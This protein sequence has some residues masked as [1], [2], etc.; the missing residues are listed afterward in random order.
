MARAASIIR[1]G[2]LVAFPTE[3]VYGL[4]ANALDQAAVLRI[5]AAKERA[6]HDPLIVHIAAVEDLDAVAARLPPLTGQLAARFWPGPLTLVVPRGPAVAPAVSAGLD[7]VAV[8][9]PSHAVALAVIRAAGVPIAAPSA[10]RF[11][12]TSATTAAHV[13]DDLDGRIDLILD[14]GPATVGVESTVLD[15]CSSPPRLLRPGAIPV[16]AIVAVIGEVAFG[17]PPAV[18]AD[19]RAPGMLDRHYAPRAH[20]TYLVGESPWAAAEMRR[21]TGEA[22]ARGVTVGQLLT[23]GS[24]AAPVP[25]PGVLVE[26]L[27]NEGDIETIA[28]RLYAAIRSLDERGAGEVFVAQPGSAGLARAVH[29]R[30]TRAASE[31]VRQDGV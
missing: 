7:T 26:V 12:H 20:L 15:L 8:R 3:T 25:P 29:D 27:G 2:G 24:A 17:P 4:G 30:L 22:I 1:A 21:R 6:A 16:E 19:V 9:M 11:M 18:D 28:A 10:N 13:R 23:L 14:G 5:F 31:I